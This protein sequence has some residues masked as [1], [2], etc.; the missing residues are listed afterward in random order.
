VSVNVVP[1]PGVQVVPPFVLNSQVAPGI[2]PETFTRPLLVMPSVLDEPVSCAS[3]KRGTDNGTSGPTIFDHSL[4]PTALT[5]R[6]RNQ[7]CVPLTSG[8]AVAVTTDGSPLVVVAP[9]NVPLVA[10]W[11][12]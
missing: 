5:A 8:E 1:M 6:T 7:Y 12:S 3:A 2:R 10:C 4:S 9:T 11:I